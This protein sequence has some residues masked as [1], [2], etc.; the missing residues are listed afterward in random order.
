M[1]RL[2]L[3]AAGPASLIALLAVPALAAGPVARPVTALA[4]HRVLLA[5][6]EGAVFEITASPGRITDLVLEPGEAL[7]AAGP[8]AAGDTAR[9]VIGDT[10]SG[11]GQTRRVHVLIKPTLARIATNLVVNTDRRTYLVNLRA[12]AQGGLSQVVWR[13]PKAEP[14]APPSAAPVAPVPLVAAAPAFDPSRL[15]FTY[16]IKGAHPRW[17]PQRV[18]DDGERTYVE[19]GSAIAMGDL[20]PLFVVGGDGRSAELINYRVAGRRIVVDRLFDQAELRFGL[21][22]LEARVRLVRLATPPQGKAP[23]R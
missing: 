17:R 10:I 14:I 15:N 9:W 6:E 23:V 21:K 18:F 5:Y 8:I 7:V 2:P 3:R 22:R 11:S 19:F 4:S 20:P 16:R 1:T 12:V 13:Y